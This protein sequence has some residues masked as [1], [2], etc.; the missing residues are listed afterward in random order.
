MK[1][2]I[3]ILA[4]FLLLS[5]TPSIKLD[6]HSESPELLECRMMFGE[7]ISELK[8]LSSCLLQ[9]GVI[10]TTDEQTPVRVAV[11]MIGRK[12]LIMRL[13]NIST[14]QGA[15]QQSYS[16]DGYNLTLSYHDN[17]LYGSE[18][19]FKGKFIIIN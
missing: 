12:Y 15:V 11:V 16:G 5:C 14:N 8:E 7:S 4:F 3:T 19:I 9:T 18:P 10:D 13:V 6:K 1:V 17:G 2:S